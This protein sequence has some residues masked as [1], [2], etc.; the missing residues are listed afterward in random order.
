MKNYWQIEQEVRAAA[1]R[2]QGCVVL[3]PWG[4]EGVKRACVDPTTIEGF[5]VPIAV[6]DA[7]FTP[8]AV[9][10]DLI[11]HFGAKKSIPFSTSRLY[12]CR[13]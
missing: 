4:R 3:I 5:P 2:T 8:G 13:P 1:I 10:E 7:G 6:Y 9:I 12:K 11:H